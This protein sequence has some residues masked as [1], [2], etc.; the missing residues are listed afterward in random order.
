MIGAKWY[1]V[2]AGFHFDPK[3][4]ELGTIL[5]RR[6][7]VDK[8]VTTELFVERIA[9]LGEFARESGVRLL[10]ENHVLSKSN[11]QAF[12]LENPLLM[13][14]PNEM[15]EVISQT[16]SNVGI[17]MDVGHLK[18]SG[19]TLGFDHIEALREVARLVEG[20]QLSEND[21][22]QDQHLMF[23]E[24]SWFF[25]ILGSKVDYI[26]FEVED[27]DMTKAIELSKKLIE[28]KLC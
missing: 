5:Q 15:I 23:D 17:L 6:P 8:R 24:S 21:G 10:I 13:V 25:D 16:N 22:L 1:G 11:F 2:H 28:S 18:V 4:S 26:T 3:P 9:N 27:L 7:L 19:N 12:H 14:T 20:Y